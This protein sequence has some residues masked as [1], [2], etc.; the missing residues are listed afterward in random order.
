[1]VFSRWQKDFFRSRSPDFE[2]SNAA[3]K[4]A[5]QQR[6]EQLEAKLQ[7]IMWFTRNGRHGKLNYQTLPLP[8]NQWVEE[9]VK[10]SVLPYTEDKFL[11]NENYQTSQRGGN[12][13]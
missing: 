9:R 2:K 7:A 8:Q 6:I 5:E 10:N 1:M 13:Y 11:F 12:A 3:K 4:Q